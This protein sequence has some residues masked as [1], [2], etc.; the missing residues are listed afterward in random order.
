MTCTSQQAI[1]DAYKF[2]AGHCQLR[3]GEQWDKLKQWNE[4]YGI[5]EHFVFRSVALDSLTEINQL[6]MYKLLG[7]D[8][9][10]FKATDLDSELETAEYKDWNVGG[11]MTKLTVRAFRNLPIHVLIACGAADGKS[12]DNEPDLP[13]K[14]ARRVQGFVDV[15]GYL[16]AG[17]LTADAE[18]DTH[19]LFLTQSP[20]RDAKSRLVNL[21]DAYLDNTDMA[22]IIAKA[23]K[24]G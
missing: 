9:S 10:T 5:P 7:V 3:E 24:K 12:K 21:D 17:K 19:R 15:V 1:A 14:L 23:R 4:L 6:I 16:E 2:V 11:E 8:V 20:K 22:T 18:K 13:G